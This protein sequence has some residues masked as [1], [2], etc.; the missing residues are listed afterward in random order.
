MYAIC[1]YV[2]AEAGE[3]VRSHGTRVIGG[4]APL[5]LWLGTKLDSFGREAG[6]LNHW[7]TSPAP[8]N[9]SYVRTLKLRTEKHFL[10]FRG[11]VYLFLKTQ[12]FRKKG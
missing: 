3:G 5:T 2:R 4:C 12:P 11:S 8:R 1:V 10:Q 9:V 7:V 6:T